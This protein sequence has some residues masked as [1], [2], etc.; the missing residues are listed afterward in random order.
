MLTGID[1]VRSGR[2]QTLL[3]GGGTAGVLRRLVHE[4]DVLNPW[5]ER[6]RL[7]EIPVE[8][9][10]VCQNTYEEAM[11]AKA[12]AKKRDWDQLVL[13][14]S[15]LHMRRVA[16]EFRSAGLVVVT[17]ACDFRSKPP[18]LNV[19]IPSSGRLHLLKA[20]LHELVGIAT[21]RA[22]GWIVE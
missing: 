10:G 5:I 18:S 1:L 20:Y 8:H 4:F 17:V 19:L 9:L 13:V 7:T 14:T 6:W 12:L 21:Y 22:R 11:E 2:G 16:A 3:L 15:A